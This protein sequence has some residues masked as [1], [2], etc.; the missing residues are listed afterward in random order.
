VVTLSSSEA[1]YLA[2][3][4]AVTETRFN[5]HLLNDMGMKVE[6][7]FMIGCDNIGAIFEKFGCWCAQSTH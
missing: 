1:E 3:S 7:P 5:Y 4:N 2:I 6:I